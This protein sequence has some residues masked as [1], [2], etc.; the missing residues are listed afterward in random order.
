MSIK[1]NKI[2]IKK[3]VKKLCNEINLSARVTESTHFKICFTD[4]FDK[5]CFC[6]LSKTPSDK[7]S[8]HIEIALIRRELK[9]NFDIAVSRDNFTI[10][11]Q[12]F[13]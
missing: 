6:V 12:T 8:R 9:R 11:F 3:T 4:K 7:Q 5:K 2:F 13:L 10:Q 1:R